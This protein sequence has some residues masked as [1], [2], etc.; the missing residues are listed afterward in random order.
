MTKKPLIQHWFAKVVTLAL[1]V[2]VW[3]VIKKSI[4]TTASRS[5]TPPA[6]QYFDLSIDRN[7]RNTNVQPAPKK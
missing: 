4:E 7:E 6:S 5:S 1:A 3:A 2:V